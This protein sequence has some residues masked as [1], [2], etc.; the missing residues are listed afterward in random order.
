MKAK[1][2][3]RSSRRDRVL[4]LDQ[5]ATAPRS[6]AL[7]IALWVA[8]VLLALFFLSSGLGRALMPIDKMAAAPN[9][10]WSAAV[11][12]PLLRFIGI[13]EALGALGLVLPAATRIKP[14]L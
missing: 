5:A 14:G 4:T 13:A 3:V 11:P 12:P 2:W 1:Q 8:Q 6:K 10:A 7:H 9:M